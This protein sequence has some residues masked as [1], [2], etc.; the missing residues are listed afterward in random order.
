LEVFVARVIK[1]TA[2]WHVTP[3]GAIEC[4]S[5][6]EERAAPITSAAQIT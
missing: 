4:T 3:C 2:C 1:I 6:S 5:V